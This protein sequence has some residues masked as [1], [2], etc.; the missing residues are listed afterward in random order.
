MSI[1]SNKT[2]PTLNTSHVVSADSMYKA[3]VSSFG[4][5][6]FC[7]CAC[8][9]LNTS[10]EKISTLSFLSVGQAFELQIY[11][12]RLF[13]HSTSSVH[14]CLTGRM[15]GKGLFTDIFENNISTQGGQA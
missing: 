7:L 6:Y 11:E 4:S 8:E 12:Q 3:V 13:M 15:E 2:R 10:K 1:R 5:G 14:V 9:C